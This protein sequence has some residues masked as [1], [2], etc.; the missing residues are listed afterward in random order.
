[1]RDNCAVIRLTRPLAPQPTYRVAQKSRSK[2]VRR[3][4]KPFHRDSPLKRSGVARVND[5][6]QSFTRHPYARPQMERDTPEFTPKLQ[7]FIALWPVP[8]S[9]PAGIAG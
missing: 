4:V 9:R 5:G 3:F 7:N 1:M 2:Y 8:I 6:S